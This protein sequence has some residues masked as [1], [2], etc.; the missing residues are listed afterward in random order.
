M[1]SQPP[2]PCSDY[3][4]TNYTIIVIEQTTNFSLVPIVCTRNESLFL[5]S[6]DGLQPNKAYRLVIQ[7][8]NAVGST[9]SEEILFCKKKM[10]LI[11]AQEPTILSSDHYKLNL[12]K[13]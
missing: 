10:I 11:T 3:P 6:S 5:S 13:I 4:V 9:F 1:H 12:S 2:D 7:A 8:N